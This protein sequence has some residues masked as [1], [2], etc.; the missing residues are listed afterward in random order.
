MEK[1]EDK[2]DLWQS[3]LPYPPATSQGIEYYFTGKENNAL[4][5]VPKEY[6]IQPYRFEVRQ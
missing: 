5:V 2:E 4:I 3:E 1:V 6:K